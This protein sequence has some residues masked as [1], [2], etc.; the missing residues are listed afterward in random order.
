MT[1]DITPQQDALTWLFEQHGKAGASATQRR[2]KVPLSIETDIAPPKTSMPPFIKGKISD[3]ALIIQASKSPQFLCLMTGEDGGH[4]SASE[5]DLA[6]ANMIAYYSSDPDQIDRI[7]RQ[8]ARD[9]DKWDEQRGARTYGQMTID[10]ALTGESAAAGHQARARH[11][12]SFNSMIFP[13]NAMNAIALAQPEIAPFNLRARTALSLF[14][15]EPPKVK[16]LIHRILPLGKVAIL[17]SPPG[18]GKS[19]LALQLALNVASIPSA[20]NPKF[21]LGGRVEA[22]GRVVVISAEDD[23]EEMHRR[24]NTLRGDDPMPGKMH[25]VSLPDL[26]YFTLV[27]GDARRSMAPSPR[28]VALKQEILELDDVRLI[29]VD[30]LQ[31]VSI[32]DLNAA[33]VAQAMMNEL[34]ELA[35]QIGASVLVLHHLV[36]GTAAVMQHGLLN[37]HSAMDAIRGSGAI[38]GSARAAYCLFPHPYGEKVCEEMGIKFEE[39][40]VVYGLVGKANGDARRERTIY[41][42]DERGVLQDRTYESYRLSQNSDDLL[43]AELLEAMIAAYH[44]GEGFSAAVTSQTGLHK[45]RHELPKQFHELPAAWFTKQAEALVQAGKLYMEKS[46]RG[47]KFAPV[48]NEVDVSEHDLEQDRDD[49]DDEHDHHSANRHTTEMQGVADYIMSD[50]ADEKP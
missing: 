26:G 18:V 23:E 27:E 10:K 36:K 32:G 49:Q 5:A 24:L 2:G 46:T 12:A 43:K 8:S 1:I 22:H 30:T 29:V 33:E 34:T 15:G 19:M 31:A 7:F 41:I 14:I 42:R 50:Q 37:A 48:A 35:N 13:F 20:V 6:L 3:A 40:K 9:R 21:S 16:W 44:R 45:R 28:W 4:A 39:N 47:H 38:V 17:A 11:A 25:I